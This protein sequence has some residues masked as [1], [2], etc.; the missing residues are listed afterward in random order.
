[1]RSRVEIKDTLSKLNL[2]LSY[3]VRNDAKSLN[4][5]RNIATHGSD[6]NESREDREDGS[7][8]INI[9]YK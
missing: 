6:V 3:V 1:M 4:P 7:H 5:T 9:I 8:N 2:N